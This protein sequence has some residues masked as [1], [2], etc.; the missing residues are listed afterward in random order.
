MKNKPIAGLT[1][2]AAVAPVTLAAIVVGLDRSQRTIPTKQGND[3]A[4]NYVA[5]A[6]LA[7]ALA[8]AA[9]A[10]A[11]PQLAG[12]YTLTWTDA[13]D[14]DVGPNVYPVLV[15]VVVRAV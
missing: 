10:S 9:P 3:N 12:R 15:T 4:Q 1:G 11:D 2:A 7:A 14:I 13:A 5:G 6:A 8:S